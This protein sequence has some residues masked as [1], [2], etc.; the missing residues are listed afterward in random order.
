MNSNENL[1]KEKEITLVTAF[2]D[3][4][5]KDFNSIPR[6]NQEY[7]NYFKVWGKMKNKIVVYTNSTMA[8]EVKKY[9]EEWGLLDKTIIIEMENELE[10]EK[11]ILE[12]MKEISTNEYFLNYRKIKNAIS[13]NYK[14]DYIMLLKYWCLY[15]AVKNKYVNGIVSWMDFG[16]NHL[17]DCYTNPE[18]FNFEWKTELEEKIHLFTLG[19][20]TTKPIFELV[21]T[22]EDNVMGC[23]IILPSK[24][25]EEFWK[26]V[27]QSMNELLNV[28][29]IDDDQ[30]LLVMAYRKHPEIFELH[31]SDWFLP[32]KEH[33]ASHLTVKEKKE[34]NMSRKILK[35]IKNIIK[36]R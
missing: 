28:G 24:Y 17:D 11:E 15:D 7:L 4:G 29:F 9:R 1:V 33:G 18:E 32:L 26:L 19:E 21:R 16:F 25:C 8:K 13:N 14:Y 6:T 12:Q 20:I 31:K 2:F 5:R 10:I 34:E 30:L 22:L 35:K 3:I 36:G 23:L 27:L